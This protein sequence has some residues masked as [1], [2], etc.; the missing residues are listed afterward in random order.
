[1]ASITTDAIDF[2]LMAEAQ[3]S[4]D[5]LSQYR[6]EDS[7]L[8]LQDVPLPTGTGTITC[9][10][11][12]GQERPFVPATLRR[13]VFNA[14]YNLS[15]PGV[16][17]TVKPITDRFVWSNINRDVRRWTRSCL[18]CQ[19]AKTHWH[20]TTPPGTFATPDARF[21]HV[22]IDLVGPLPPSNGS[23]YMLTCIDRFTRWPVA[24]PIPD[25]SAET[26]ARA[27]L[28]HWVSNFGVPA[29]VTTDR[30]S[31]F[32]STLFREL[33]CLLGTNR[34][35]T[36]AYHPQANGLVERF[37]RQ[38]KIPLWPSPILPDGLITFPWCCCPSVPL[39]RPTSVE[40]QLILS[41][42]PPYDCPGAYEDSRCKCV[43]V[44]HSVPENHDKNS[45]EPTRAV[46]VKSIPADKC[47]CPFMLENKADLCPYCD[48]KYQVRNTSTIKVVVC[49]I[50]VILSALSLYLVF[51]LL[52]EPFLTARGRKINFGSSACRPGTLQ[53]RTLRSFRNYTPFPDSDRLAQKRQP[54][55][56]Y[57]SMGAD[58]LAASGSGRGDDA[59]QR[60][61]SSV[62][63]RAR[64][65]QSTIEAQR[66]RVFNERTI[67]N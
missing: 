67:L 12:T 7:S 35:R 55:G 10:L 60:R 11:S 31:Q 3:R 16:R 51:M 54:V 58:N 61:V 6:H 4:D 50:V 20:T 36:T 41:T 65:H 18:S 48:C 52:L 39:S 63:N 44:D 14:L 56:E 25:I 53:S 28:N 64:E 66:D 45:T 62:V 23:N 27:F 5:E 33:T 43:C 8:R 9:D 2:T 32:E 47:T 15:Q 29:T 22:H 30:G 49:L 38:L 24:V 37:H 34:N 46:Y 57:N 1:M 13:R 17:A 42:E 59:G 21:S 26:V 40:L 19:R